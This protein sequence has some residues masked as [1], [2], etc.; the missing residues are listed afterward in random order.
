MSNKN[1]SQL[2]NISLLMTLIFCSPSGISEEKTL[3]PVQLATLKAERIAREKAAAAQN[4]VS[5][6]W[7]FFLQCFKAIVVCFILF[8][9]SISYT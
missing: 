6:L 7:Y 5:N 9:Y 3:N 1:P 8:V 4:A 2:Q